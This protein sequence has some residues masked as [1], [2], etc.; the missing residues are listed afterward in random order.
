MQGIEGKIATVDAT[1][2][3]VKH[4][5]GSREAPIVNTAILGAFAKTTGIVKIE[6]LVESILDSAL[7]HCLAEENPDLDVT[8]HHISSGIDP[9]YER[10]G[11]IVLLRGELP[12][13]VVRRRAFRN[14]V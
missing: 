1:A 7:V 5:L 2:I 13:V 12:C 3:A 11:E 9:G 4:G 6:S 10:R 14:A 8:V